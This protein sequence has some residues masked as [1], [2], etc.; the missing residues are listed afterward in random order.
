[1]RIASYRLCSWRGKKKISAIL[2]YTECAYV[3]QFF[4]VFYVAVYSV[5]VSSAIIAIGWLLFNTISKDI[6]TL[7]LKE[8]VI[9]RVIAASLTV[10]KEAVVKEEKKIPALPH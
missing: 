2:K 8:S 4:R 9:Q 5:F 1:M 7:S 3:R 10:V 6:I